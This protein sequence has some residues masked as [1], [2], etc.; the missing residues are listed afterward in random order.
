MKFLNIS[1][2]YE[3]PEIHYNPPFGGPFG[4]PLFFTVAYKPNGKPSFLKPSAARN[5]KG[6][7]MTELAELASN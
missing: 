7:D 1:L 3:R 2:T 6:V 5:E 4:G